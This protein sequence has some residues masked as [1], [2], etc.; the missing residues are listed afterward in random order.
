[1]DIHHQFARNHESANAEFANAESASAEPANVGA[2]CTAWV[3]GA[4]RTPPIRR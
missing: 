1:M 4:S 3:R 2:A